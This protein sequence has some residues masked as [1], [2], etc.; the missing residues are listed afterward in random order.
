MGQSKNNNM[1][2]VILYLKLSLLENLSN[3][4]YI[5]PHALLIKIHKIILKG[6]C[7]SSHSSNFFEIKRKYEHFMKN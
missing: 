7:G 6:R 1:I 3:N 4:M 2:Q 5:K